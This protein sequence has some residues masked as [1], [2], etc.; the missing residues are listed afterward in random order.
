MKESTILVTPSG[1]RLRLVQSLVEVGPEEIE[2]KTGEE[3]SDSEDDTQL[4]PPA[5][6]VGGLQPNILPSNLRKLKKL[7]D[8]GGTRALNGFRAESL[9]GSNGIVEDDKKSKTKR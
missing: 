3:S 5:D 1:Q 8:M 4:P 2:E 9:P 7:K 6:P